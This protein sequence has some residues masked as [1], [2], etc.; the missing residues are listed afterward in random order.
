MASP[1]GV[2]VHAPQ[3]PEMNAAFDRLKAAGI[4]W[5]RIDFIWAWAEPV[6]GKYDWRVYDAIAAAANARGL[7]VYATLAYTP[8]WAT[9]GPAVTGVP[10]TRTTGGGSASA[11]PS[12]T[13]TRSGTGG[14]GTSPTCRASGPAA[15]SSTSTSS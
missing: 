10:G 7:E 15:A 4:G 12:A 14:C 2:N 9:Y 3:G 8:A 1:F 5:V 13:A 6:R 11:P